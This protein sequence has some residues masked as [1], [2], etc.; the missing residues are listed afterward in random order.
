MDQAT[1]EV[2]DRIIEKDKDSLSEDERGFLM[3]RRSYLNEEQRARYAD[4]IEEHEANIGKEEVPLEEMNLKQLKAEAK[5][6]DIDIKGLKTE[7][8]IR[9]AI[10]EAGE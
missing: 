5:K 3:A 9:D 8:E 7:D 10:A 6:R 2:F 1:K 4:M